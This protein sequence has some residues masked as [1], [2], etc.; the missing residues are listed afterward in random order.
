MKPHIHAEIIKA[1]ADGAQIQYKNEDMISWEDMPVCNPNWFESVDYRVKPKP[2]KHIV[3][4]F[5][6]SSE[7]GI[8]YLGEEGNNYLPANLQ[9]TFDGET[10]T[11]IS[12]KVIQ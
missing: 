7:R 2:K 3:Q 8:V 5:N 11:L 1:W 4:F 9:L 10:K 12:A 6:V